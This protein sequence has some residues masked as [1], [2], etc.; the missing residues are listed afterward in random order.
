MVLELGAYLKLNAKLPMNSNLESFD[1]V[2]FVT[3]SQ[4]E[5]QYSSNAVT[6]SGIVI[7]VSPHLLKELC[8]IW[9]SVSGNFICLSYLQSQNA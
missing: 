8:H 3:F 6:L 4:P 1:I 5:K 2:I 7:S 9:L